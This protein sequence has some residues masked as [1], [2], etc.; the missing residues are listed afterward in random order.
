MTIV[1]T[2]IVAPIDLLGQCPVRLGPLVDGVESMLENMRDMSAEFIQFQEDALNRTYREEGHLYLMRPRMMRWEY[3]TP[4]EKLFISDGG[5]LYFYVP[6]DRQVNRDR[7]SD[8]FDDRIPIMFLLGR[9]DLEQ[10]FTDIADVTGIAEAKVPGSC[11]MEMNPRR[12]SEFVG[13]LLEVDAA[14]FDIRRLRLS[15]TD[16]SVSDFVF[17]QVQTNRD[18]SEE[19]F[20]FVPPPGIRIVDGIGN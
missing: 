14:T 18:L 15:S 9:S 3:R 11:V 19:L 20:D 2:V 10:E 7:V 12:E 4:E 5:D 13:V 16:G 6:A 8:A 17:N 1:I